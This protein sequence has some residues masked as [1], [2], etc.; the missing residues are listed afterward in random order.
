VHH[1]LMHSVLTSLSKTSFLSLNLSLSLSLSPPTVTHLCPS[2][3][4]RVASSVTTLCSARF[5]SLH[6]RRVLTRFSCTYV[7]VQCVCMCVTVW[8]CVNESLLSVVQFTP[9]SMFQLS[10]HPIDGVHHS[11]RFHLRKCSHWI[12]W[13]S[14]SF[15]FALQPKGLSVPARTHQREQSRTCRVQSKESVQRQTE[16]E[17]AERTS[18]AEHSPRF[19]CLFAQ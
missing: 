2:L 1:S 9:F 3:P 7:C 6:P 16:T 19:W 12:G 5:S 8:H 13:K 15:A 11:Y 18:I 17:S 10:R 4:I 14:S